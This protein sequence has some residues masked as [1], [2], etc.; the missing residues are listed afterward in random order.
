MLTRKLPCPSCGVGLKIAEDLPAGKK[1]NCPKCGVGFAV[2]QGNGQASAAKE[3]AVRVRKPIPE[4][5]EEYGE[6][7]EVD[8]EEV[9]GRPVVRKRRAPPPPEDDDEPDDVEEERPLRRKRRKFKKKKQSSRMPLILGSVIGAVLLLGAAGVTAAVFLLKDNKSDSLAKNPAPS[10]PS[11]MPGGG[12]GGGEGSAGVSDEKAS[13]SSGREASESKPSESGNDGASDQYAAG[14]QVFQR[15]CT[16]CHRISG[17]DGG[18]RQGP[19]LSTIGREHDAEWLTE[20]IRDPKSKKPDSRMRP[21]RLSD[22][23]LH[24]VA[25]YLASLK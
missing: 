2:P 19:D 23:D 5:P 14:K 20:F 6:Q 12:P 8:D 18:G 11:R 15:S 1:I 16:R 3:S 25:A 10:R 21:V 7:D 4:D 24:A 13:S 22:P 9:E 17:L